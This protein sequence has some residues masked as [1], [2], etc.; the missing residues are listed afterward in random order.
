MLASCVDIASLRFPVLCTPKY[1]GIRCLIRGGVPVSRTLTPIPNL[2]VQR[3]LKDVPDGLDG[4]LICLNDFNKTQAGIMSVDAETDFTYNVFDIVS[5]DP[6]MDRMECLADTYLPPVCRRVLPVKINTRTSL[7]AYET[8]C[9]EAGF[10]GIMIRSP[11][12]PY[13]YGRSTTKEGYL[14]KLKRFTDAEAKIIG[15]AERMRNDNELTYDNLGYAR[16]SS[17]QEGKVPT[18][19][20]GAFVVE[21][22]EGGR[23]KVSTG[24]T[25]ADRAMYWSMR[26]DCIGHFIKF[27]YQEAGAKNVPRFP[28]FLGFRDVIDM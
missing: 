14:L 24:M 25:N 20:L 13:K 9:L 3:I 12:G 1:D 28:V 5:E 7:L 11:Y 26:E 17:S 18:D 15:Y 8:R 2:H 19:T 21:N 16:R 4:E 6:Y 22:E 10:E 23:F 27:K